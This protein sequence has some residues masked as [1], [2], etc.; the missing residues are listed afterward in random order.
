MARVFVTGG[1]GF[2]GRFLVRN[3]SARNCQVA[4]LV[5]R[6]PRTGG[7]WPAAAAPV[8]GDILE[9][10]AYRR[11]IEKADFVF[12]LAGCL[13]SPRREDFWRINV[14]GLE[15]LLDC[16]MG[17]TKPPRIVVVSSL[18]AAGPSGNRPRTEADPPRPV[19]DYGRSKL[20]AERLAARYADRL[21]IT[22]VRPP[23]VLGEG[24]TMGWRMFASVARWGVH[25][26]PTLRRTEYSLIHVADLVDL[27]WGAAHSD[28]V[29]Q[30][31]SFHRWDQ[32]SAFAQSA[33][34]NSW[35]SPPPA[36][37]DAV[38]RGGSPR[39]G[40]GR[41]TFRTRGEASSAEQSLLERT[42]PADPDGVFF[43][44]AEAMTYAE[45][46]RRIAAALGR[47]RVLVLPVA[48]AIIRWAGRAGQWA[49]RISGRPVYLNTDKAREI[50]AG[51]WVC[52]ADKAR[53]LLGFS[54]QPF[55]LRLKETVESYRQAGLLR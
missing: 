15:Q 43:A 24:D 27:L 12:H 39:W 37:G 18:A 35:G 10:D 8:Y 48:A 17:R 13:R 16:C 7:P 19:S 3:L 33:R 42:A 22:I 21:P 6:D 32:Q 23:I 25:L 26:H 47:R 28:H 51:S 4:A 5:R 30:P 34:E 1:R 31:S 40:S 36:A 49:G 55:S 46:G 50:T 53:R 2:I 11:E 29:V 14:G 38:L 20:D 54:P 44:A 45:L 52:S 9:P 41:A